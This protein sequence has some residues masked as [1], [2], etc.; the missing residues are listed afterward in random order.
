[1]A[2][3]VMQANQGRYSIRETAGLFGVS[4]GASY[5]RAKNGVSERRKLRDAELVRLIREIQGK[6]HTRYGSLRVREAL[7]KGYGKR[8]S[9]K[10]AA[11]AASLPLMR[12]NGLKACVRRKYIPTTT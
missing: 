7:R 6:H 1:M 2:Y 8:V 5:R 10:N 12:E 4:G 9:R 3:R 11:V